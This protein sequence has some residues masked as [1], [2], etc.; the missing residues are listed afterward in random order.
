MPT[1]KQDPPCF[2]IVKYEFFD[3]RHADWKTKP[4]TGKW[5]HYSEDNGKSMFKFHTYDKT[6]RGVIKVRVVA[7]VD[8][9]RNEDFTL[10]VEFKN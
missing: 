2:G 8:G 3:A 9:A 5:V 7:T 6:L 10:K 4:V 1:F